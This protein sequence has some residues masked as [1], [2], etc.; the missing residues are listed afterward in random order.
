MIYRNSRTGSADQNQSLLRVGRTRL[1]MTAV[2]T[3][4]AFFMVGARV[5]WFAIEGSDSWVSLSQV[6]ESLPFT[7][8]I[9]T[10]NGTA[11][12]GAQAG[13]DKDGSLFTSGEVIKKKS[14]GKPVQSL[15]HRSDIIDR[16]GQILATD[17]PTL[18]LA[19][20]PSR[21]RDRRTLVAKISDIIP[22][23]DVSLSKER[24]GRR[25]LRFAW[26]HRAVTPP[27]RER[28]ERLGEAGLFFRRHL[29]RIY[30]EGKLFAHL[31]G[32]T[33]IDN[34]G[35][36][37]VEYGLNE[38]ISH[39]QAPLRLTL[40]A[41][42]QRIAYEE[43][44][45]ALQ[46]TGAL[47]GAVVLL[48][49]EL[50]GVLALASLPDLEPRSAG[51]GLVEDSVGSTGSGV[52]SSQRFNRATYG[53]YELGSVLKIFTAATALEEGIAEPNTR[54]NV[55]DSLEIGRLI[56][57][58]TEGTPAEMTLSEIFIRSSN[59]GAARLGL[60]VGPENMRAI[61]SRF[62]LL[63][64]VSLEMPERG[65]PLTA[66]SWRAADTAAAS[67][68][69][70]LAISPLHL[71]IGTAVAV[72]GGT[73]RDP[74]LVLDRQGGES[75]QVIRVSTSK[76]LRSLM[77][78]NVIHGTGKLAMSPFVEVGGKTGTAEKSAKRGGYDPDRVIV[79]FVAAYPIQQPRHVLVVMVDE[80]KYALL[81]DGRPNGSSVAAPVAKRIIDRIV[82]A[83]GWP[84]TR[85]DVTVSNTHSPVVPPNSRLNLWVR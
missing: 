10:A 39:R 12:T 85:R 41:A 84:A 29:R 63:D 5:T 27:E 21:I 38:L 4:V 26:L 42:Y 11:T 51:G 68:G 80:P 50:L 13:G 61:F 20:D 53:M 77:R 9:K 28:I 55:K 71:A 73:Y 43:L 83:S 67:Y 46:Q 49:A 65:T 82:P 15:T 2:V 40:D 22:R 7:D 34:H 59:L 25:D 74:T 78:L 75:R 23:L 54:V 57:E 62:G 31:L 33:D 18:G 8:S 19:A 17:L 70:G 76:A 52:D 32:R 69:Y 30:P 6:I 58:P 36:S 72:N 3:C 60:A 35:I 56:L 66:P 16:N 24:L 48:D 79:T 14:S 47:G 1:A 64:R 37:G 45:N 81:S 44:F